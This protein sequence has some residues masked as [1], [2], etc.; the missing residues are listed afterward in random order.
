LKIFGKL[1]ELADR[2][3]FYKL[4]DHIAKAMVGW[5]NRKV[6]AIDYFRE[7]GWENLV[8]EFAEFLDFIRDR[9]DA[10][11][12]WLRKF[13]VSVLVE[14]AGSTRTPNTFYNQTID[15]ADAKLKDQL[16]RQLKERKEENQ[17]PPQVMLDTDLE[18]S[19]Y[20]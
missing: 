7:R 11:V 4:G 19:L 6:Q 1:F 8:G 17:D 14:C 16:L 2:F 9:D 5:F 12:F 18:N 3:L 10:S 15:F 13:A 20:R